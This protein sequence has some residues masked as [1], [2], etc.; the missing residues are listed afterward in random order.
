MVTPACWG[1]VSICSGYGNS[2][3]GVRLGAPHLRV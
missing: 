2:S 3:M 1:L